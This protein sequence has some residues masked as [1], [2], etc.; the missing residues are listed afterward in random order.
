MHASPLSRSFPILAAALLGVGCSSGT[1]NGQDNQDPV[2]IDGT[3]YARCAPGPSPMGPCVATGPVSGAVVGT[4][5]NQS[6]ATT[7]AAGHFDLKAGLVV[8]GGCTPY[9][10]TITAAGMGTWS[11]TGAWGTGHVSGQTFYMA[12]GGPKGPIG[13]GCT[14]S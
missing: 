6:T 5:L 1:D 2:E 7:D 11:G 10:I 13:V 12:D 9:T 3:V 8:Q 4:S 14:S